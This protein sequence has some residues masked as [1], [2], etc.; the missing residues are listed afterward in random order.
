MR[1]IRVER[2][3][4]SERAHALTCCFVVEKLPSLGGRVPP[5]PPPVAPPPPV[6][7]SP[8]SRGLA[9]STRTADADPALPAVRP[10]HRP[11]ILA[12]CPPPPR[13]AGVPPGGAHRVGRVPDR[14]PRRQSPLG[15]PG[16][17]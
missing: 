2:T 8:Q 6:P 12:R 13:L 9:P 5:V 10:G 16:R 17:R 1:A 4:E 3:A 14:R 11:S 7:L 15:R